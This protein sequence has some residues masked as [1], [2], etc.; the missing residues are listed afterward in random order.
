[1]ELQETVTEVIDEFVEPKARTDTEEAKIDCENPNDARAVID[2]GSENEVSFY[3]VFVIL[4]GCQVS[5]NIR[6]GQRN[7]F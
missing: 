2:V 3:I 1:M 7:L 5:S 6:Q 4:I